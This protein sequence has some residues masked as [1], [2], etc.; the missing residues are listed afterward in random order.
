M[1]DGVGFSQRILA[2]FGVFSALFLGYWAWVMVQPEGIFE[3]GS[4]VSVGADN[5]QGADILAALEGVAGTENE[6]IAVAIEQ[7]DFT[8]VYAAGE[9]GDS[10]Y[11]TIEPGKPVHVHP[12][13]ELPDEDSRQ[14]LQLSGDADF[15]DAVHEVLDSHGAQYRDLKN[16]EWSFLFTDTAL[17]GIYFLVLATCF[18]VVAA[19][20]I[21]RTRDYAV[22]Q[23]M[24]LSP[25][26][27]PWPRNPALVC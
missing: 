18:A 6:R 19:G 12:L 25:P 21:A 5:G 16:L 9:H 22:W 24:G 15:T 7:P 1:K 13:T 14:L 3:T 23:L 26:F 27:D 20:A 11:D 4:F 2:A 17:A 10:W 8:D